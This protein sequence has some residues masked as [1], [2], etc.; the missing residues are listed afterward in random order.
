MPGTPTVPAGL[1]NRKPWTYN[2][3]K[4]TGYKAR[5]GITTPVES[6]WVIYSG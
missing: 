5:V 3:A 4:G 2:H 6:L 1:D